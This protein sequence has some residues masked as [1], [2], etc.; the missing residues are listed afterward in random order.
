MGRNLFPQDGGAVLEESWLEREQACPRPSPPLTAGMRRWG[1]GHALPPALGLLCAAALLA[2]CG[3]P[4]HSGPPSTSASR[5]RVTVSSTG[6]TTSTVP[7]TTTVPTSEV[8]GVVTVLSPVGLNVRAGP[9]K[10]AAVIGTAAQGA[11][12]QLLARTAEGGGWYKV[13]GATALG[14]MTANPLYSARG[15]FDL[16]RSA[17]FN[18][19]LPAG[20]AATGSPATGVHFRAPVTGETVVITSAAKKLPLASQ[21]AGALET[22]SRQVVACGVTTQLRTFTTSSQ[23]H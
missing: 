21:G 6:P 7:T 8:N 13:R 4:S 23:G 20:W 12:L 5:S 22:S 18:V 3:S 15:R 2:G 14:W 11:V 16:Y 17:Q 9:S 10:K 19:L 1:T